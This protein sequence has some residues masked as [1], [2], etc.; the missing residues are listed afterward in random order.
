MVNWVLAHNSIIVM[1]DH[2]MDYVLIKPTVTTATMTDIASLFYKS[3]Y[4]RFGLPSAITSDRDKLF[5]SHFWQEL[6]KKLK[7]HLR[8]S[9][10]LH[11]KTDGS[12]ERSNKM[13][14]ESLRHYVNTRQD[15]WADHLL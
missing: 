8:M 4:R 15:D 6:F 3:W 10:A 5:I 11:P 14:I 7:V 12:S 13:A 1:M 9:M 2:F